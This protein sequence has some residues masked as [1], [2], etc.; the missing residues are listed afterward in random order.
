MPWCPLPPCLQLFDRIRAL[1]PGHELAGLLDEFSFTSMISNCV[2]Q[3][4]LQRALALME[5]RRFLLILFYFFFWCVSLAAAA[6]G[7]ECALLS[8]WGCCRMG[9]LV[10]RA[11]HS[12]QRPRQGPPRPERSCIPHTR[13][14]FALHGASSSGALP[15]GAC[16]VFKL[17]EHGR[18]IAR[19]LSAALL[20]STHRACCA[21][22][23]CRR[24]AS[25]ALSAT[26][27][28]F[29]R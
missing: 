11:E 6:G 14:C 5:A 16:P 24:C 9:G 12:R 17:G 26:C 1:G 15:P 4:D 13:P 7:P 19:R 2:G 21:V 18:S 10:G 25:A 23:P 3:Q 27:T 29:R 28:P 8:L 20:P 22:P